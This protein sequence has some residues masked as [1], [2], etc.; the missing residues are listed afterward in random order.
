MSLTRLIAIA[1]LELVRDS[2][3]IFGR[4]LDVRSKV[5]ENGAEG[6]SGFWKVGFLAWS[7]HFLTPCSL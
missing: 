4:S 1:S 2:D 3:P 5:L 6:F 7:V